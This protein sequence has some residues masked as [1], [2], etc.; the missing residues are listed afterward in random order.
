[1]LVIEPSDPGWQVG[2]LVFGL[3]WFGARRRWRSVGLSLSLAALAGTAAVLV[4]GLATTVLLALVDPLRAPSLRTLR[5]VLAIAFAL[6]AAWLFFGRPGPGSHRARPEP[7]ELDPQ[8][9]AETA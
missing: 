4:H 3:F 1:M 7:V 8:R 9:P 2:L 5:D 6:V